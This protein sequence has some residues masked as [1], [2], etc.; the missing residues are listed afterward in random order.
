MTK[1][2]LPIN[3]IYEEIGVRPMIHAGGTNTD[4]GASKMRPEGIAAMVQ[5]SQ[6]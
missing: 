1:S 4:H 3:P 5:A 2:R 6:S